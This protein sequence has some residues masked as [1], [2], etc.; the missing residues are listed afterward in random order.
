LRGLKYFQGEIICK[1]KKNEIG[2]HGKK[3]KEY[4]EKKKKY[5]TV[6]RHS[7]TKLV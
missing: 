5:G 7:N 3:C 1:V 2:K 4:N 6:M